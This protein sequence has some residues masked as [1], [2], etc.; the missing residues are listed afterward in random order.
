MAITPFEQRPYWKD[1]SLWTK[2]DIARVRYSKADGE[3]TLYCRDQHEKWQV[4]THFAHATQ[5]PP[6]P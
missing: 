5:L 1:K 6:S 4:Y 3:W 2:F